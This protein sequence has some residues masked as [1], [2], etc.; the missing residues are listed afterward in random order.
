MARIFFRK[1]IRK[2]ILS[3]NQKLK[4]KSPHYFQCS[5]LIIKISS[6][7]KNLDKKVLQGWQMTALRVI[8]SHRHKRNQEGLGLVTGGMGYYS[9]CCEKIR[10]GF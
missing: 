2:G 8:G 9:L 7:F 3:E 6:S 5:E 4:K 1:Q 10:C